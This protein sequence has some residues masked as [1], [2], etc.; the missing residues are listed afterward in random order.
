MGTRMPGSIELALSP[1][2]VTQTLQPA[3]PN[4]AAAGAPPAD[5]GWIASSKLLAVCS[6]RLAQNGRSK[7][8]LSSRRDANHVIG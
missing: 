6:C 1:V 4:C 2:H 3:A 7:T 8:E 5:E